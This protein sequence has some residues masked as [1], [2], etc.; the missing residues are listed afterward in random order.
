LGQALSRLTEEFKIKQGYEVA[1][2]VRD[3]ALVYLPH[4]PEVDVSIK[5]EPPEAVPLTRVTITNDSGESP[6]ELPVPLAPHPYNLRLPAGFYRVGA[7]IMESGS[8][9]VDFP[10]RI[11]LVMPPSAAWKVTVQS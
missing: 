8:G 10:P 1:G 6:V 5:I 2:I 7:T 3:W 9:Y 4:P 11:R